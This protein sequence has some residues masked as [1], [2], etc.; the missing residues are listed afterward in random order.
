MAFSPLLFRLYASDLAEAVH[1]LARERQ[2]G[3]LSELK[4]ELGNVPGID[5]LQVT[6]GEGMQHITLNGKTVSLGVNA[7]ID[8]IRK[9]LGLSE[10]TTAIIPQV[11]IMPA[12]SSSPKTA[13]TGI[14]GATHAGMSLKQMMADRKNKLSAAR[15]K[16]EANFGKLDQ[17]TAAL[18]SL[19]DDLGSEAD[20]L[21][22][23]IGQFKNDLG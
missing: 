1:Q 8:D 17:A 5:T 6:F 18:D 9:E 16:V 4:A 14:T 21:L 11:Q 12:L 2:M 20:D 23:S 15:A 7:S 19:G 22:A 3:S 10:P 13:T